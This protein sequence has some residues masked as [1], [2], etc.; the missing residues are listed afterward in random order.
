M[1]LSAHFDSDEF[2]CHCGCGFGGNPGDVSVALLSQLEI[3]R[4]HFGARIRILSGCRCRRHNAAV[5]GASKSRHTTGEAADIVVE[6]V[7]PKTVQVQ[8]L[9]LYPDGYGIGRYSRWT[10]FDVRPYKAR[11]TG[12]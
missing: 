1:Q 4:E 12:P 3:I 8:L 10:H 5:G 9:D 11:W 7:P 6:G 2:K